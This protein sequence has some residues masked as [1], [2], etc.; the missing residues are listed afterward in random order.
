MCFLGWRLEDHFYCLVTFCIVSIRFIVRDSLEI[1]NI[2]WPVDLHETF[3]VHLRALFPG[4]CPQIKV[5]QSVFCHSHSLLLRAAV[6]GGY[7]HPA[8]SNPKRL[9]VFH[10]V[11]QPDQC[12]NRYARQHLPNKQSF[13]G[14]DKKLEHLKI[15]PASA[16]HVWSQ[17]FGLCLLW[18]L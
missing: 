1:A 18:Q 9:S 17:L 7:T 8:L 10:I 4:A 11:F 15:F 6:C 13:R 2:K 16:R 14:R 12:Y 3:C 5:Y